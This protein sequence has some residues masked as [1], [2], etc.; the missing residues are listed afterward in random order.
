MNK[1][2]R[3]T[4]VALAACAA[5]VLAAVNA[6]GAQAAAQLT[7][8][9]QEA[10]EQ[11]AARMQV[12]FAVPLGTVVQHVTGD[13]S[14]TG[15]EGTLPAL[16]LQPPTMAANHNQLIPDPLVPQ[17]NSA[18]QTP[19]LD[20]TAPMPSLDGTVHDG[21]ATLALPAAPTKALGAALGLGHPVTYQG[22]AIPSAL[23][24]PSRVEAAQAEQQSA[25]PQLPQ[26][27][28]S[29]LQPAI[30][31]PSL[32]SAPGGQLSL[33]QR[34]PDANVVKPVQDIVADAQ[35]TLNRARF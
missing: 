5:P 35:G 27:D 26:V 32:S 13:H 24:A 33:D 4:A 2:L 15:V 17:L 28:L 6:T 12:P 31:E 30:T 20:A 22:R 34:T 8:Q 21:G 23:D 16:P 29:R 19:S 11:S 25:L 7:P 14:D 18:P 1:S 3:G 9:Q 10:L